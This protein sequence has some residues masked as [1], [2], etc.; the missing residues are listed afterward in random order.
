[1]N[2]NDII[3]NLDED[4]N[5]KNPKMKNDKSGEIKEDEHDFQ[6]GIDDDEKYEN[7]EQFE[8][9]SE[10]ESVSIHEYDSLHF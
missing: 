7:Q 2:T 8:N 9:V 3:S 10:I 6:D 1:M 4:E 5:F